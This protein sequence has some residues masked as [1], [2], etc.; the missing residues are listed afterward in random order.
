MSF[1]KMNLI[2]IFVNVICVVN[3]AVIY[4][5][6]VVSCQGLGDVQSLAG[7]PLCCV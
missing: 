2:S 4:V 1:N 6:F 7:F 3:C 5:N